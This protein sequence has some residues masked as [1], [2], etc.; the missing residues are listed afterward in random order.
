MSDYVIPEPEPKEPSFKQYLV[1]W[2][3]IFLALVVL[4]VLLGLLMRFLR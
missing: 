1:G 4:G 3:A 2:G